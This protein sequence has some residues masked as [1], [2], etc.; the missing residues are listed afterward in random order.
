MGAAAGMQGGQMRPQQPQQNNL[1]DIPPEIRQ[2]L[3][4]NLRKMSS[5]QTPQ[6]E[7]QTTE[8]PSFTLK[9]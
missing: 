2:K 6:P 9:V 7:Q 1:N 8:T 5:Q 3:E 4:E